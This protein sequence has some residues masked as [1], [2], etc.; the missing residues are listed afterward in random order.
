[1]SRHCC[2]S[3]GTSTTPGAASI[4]Q[5]R[6]D[7]NSIQPRRHF[8]V[9]LQPLRANQRGDAHILHHLVQGLRLHA[10]RPQD[11]TD[12]ALM[13]VE[14]LRACRRTQVVFF[15]RTCHL[16]PRGIVTAGS[17]TLCEKRPETSRGDVN[18]FQCKT[19]KVLP[20]SLP[21]SFYVTAAGLVVRG[22][23]LRTYA[24]QQ[25]AAN[26]NAMLTFWE[27]LSPVPKMGAS[28]VRMI[29]SRNLETG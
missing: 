23:C 29:S 8:V 13:L 22:G 18:L 6:H 24:H 1:M 3:P 7:R 25:A 28:S 12:P 14:C 11:G 17:D 19:S 9:V 5:R 21:A 10:A 2:S 15:L 20:A 26:S 27:I 16:F 4:L